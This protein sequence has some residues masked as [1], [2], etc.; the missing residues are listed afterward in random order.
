MDETGTRV[1]DIRTD[2]F[3][4][5]GAET[6]GV[7]CPFCIQ[8]LEAGIQSKGVQ[9]TR[10]VEDLLQMLVESATPDQGPADNPSS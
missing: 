3:L 4:E 6:L 8:Q 10:Q 9:E 5:T 2:H 1:S 7:S